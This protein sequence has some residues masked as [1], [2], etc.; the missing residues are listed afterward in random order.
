MKHLTLYSI[1]ISGCLLA[2]CREDNSQLGASLMESSFSNYFTDTCVVDISTVRM[3]SMVTRGDSVCQ[4]GCYRDGTW[5][6]VRATYYAEFSTTDFTPDNNHNYRLDSLVLCL[7]HS[8][9]YWG[10]TLAGQ[11]IA[12]YPLK[13][14]IDLSDDEDLYNTT[15]LP[16]E[17][18]PLHTFTLVPRPG[19]SKTTYVRLPDAWGEELLERLV[20]QDEVFDSQDDFK[21][22][23]PGL[24]FVPEADGS[25]ITGYLVTESS[26]ALTLYYKDISNTIA[27][28]SLTFQV[29]TDNAYT[30]IRHDR[31]G[32]PLAS[33]RSGVE[34]AVHS[35]DLGGRA[36][37]QGLTGFYNQIEFPTL[38]GLQSAGEIVSIE[39]ATL[40]LYPLA[41]SYNRTNQLPD[42]IRLYITDENNVLEDYVYGSDGVTVQTGNL[43]VDEVFGRDTYYSFDLTEFIRNNFGTWGMKRQKLLM[44]MNNEDAATTFNQ[45]IFTNDPNAERQCHLEIRFKTYNE[46]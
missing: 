28:K 22:E 3:D 36:Y 10:D 32:T 13:Y 11:R 4:I 44:N 27:S 26:M 34:N 43:T 38:N 37:M 17:E 30:G 9:H 42:D 18:T 35:Y 14:P 20:A 5:G 6:E 46:Q 33:I 19:K 21:N 15:R 41:G 24:A 16:L 45:A 1:L 23:F 31:S 40:Y 2:G 8:G 7:R 12:I 29:N 39:S 25:C